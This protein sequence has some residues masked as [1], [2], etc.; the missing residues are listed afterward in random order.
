[1]KGDLGFEI[2]I[3]V[4]LELVAGLG[5]KGRGMDWSLGIDVQDEDR[6]GRIPRSMKHEE[7]RNVGAWVQIWCVVVVQGGLPLNMSRAMTWD[8]GVTALS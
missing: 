7:I 3:A 4:N 2:A 5:V 6:F 1:V 8:G